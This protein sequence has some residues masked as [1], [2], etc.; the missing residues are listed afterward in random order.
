LLD[1]YKELWLENFLLFLF[2]IITLFMTIGMPTGM[3]AFMTL[4]IA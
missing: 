4:A 2:I 1:T 3:P